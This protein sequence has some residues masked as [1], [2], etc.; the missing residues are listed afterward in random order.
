[1]RKIVAFFKENKKWNTVLWTLIGIFLTVSLLSINQKENNLKVKKVKVNIAP[2]SGL[3]FLDS[4]AILDLMKGT[5]LNMIIIGEKLG[6]LKIDEMEGDL[7]HNPFVEEA[8]VSVDL[9]GNMRVKVLQRSPI[10]SIIKNKG[11]S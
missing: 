8:D 9:A 7:E 6:R 4:Q 10:L 1:M 11:Q 5:D 2:D 3:N